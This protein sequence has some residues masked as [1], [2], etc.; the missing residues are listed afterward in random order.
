M[1][2]RALSLPALIINNITIAIVPGSL[3]YKG[4]KIKT[5]VETVSSGGGKVETVHSRD[6]TEAKSEVK[7]QMRLTTDVDGKIAD[8]DDNVAEN[9]II[10]AE[11]IGKQKAK[12]IFEGM[13][14]IDD[15]ERNVSPDGTVELVFQGEQMI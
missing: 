5:N 13:S 9:V 6:A 2:K 8:W 1:S 15:P 7:F 3:T 11:V 10:F 14:L 4:G 12:R